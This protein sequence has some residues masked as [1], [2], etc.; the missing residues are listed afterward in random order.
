METQRQDLEKLGTVCKKEEFLHI[1]LNSLGKPYADLSQQ[2]ARTINAAT[3]PLTVEKVRKEIKSYL[4]IIGKEERKQYNVPRRNP[5]T[6]LIAFSKPFKGRCNKCG[7]RAGYKAADCTERDPQVQVSNFGGERFKGRC[8]HCNKVGHP[9]SDCNQLK[10][11]RESGNL[12]IDNGPEEFVFS[13]FDIDD[14]RNKIVQLADESVDSETKTTTSN[15]DV[16]MV[17]NV[18]TENELLHSLDYS[19]QQQENADSDSSQD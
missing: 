12:A 7:K 19:D 9:K 1:L 15:E 10:A 11:Q 16:A 17:K 18:T 8:F 5:E 13:A 2:L 14:Q 3:D 4:K 6:V